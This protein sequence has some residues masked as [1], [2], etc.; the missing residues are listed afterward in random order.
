MS[1][2]SN[3]TATLLLVLMI[4]LAARGANQYFMPGDAFFHTVLTEELLGK[5]DEQADP[6]FIYHRP[7]FLPQM[8]CGYAGFQQLQYDK[9]PKSM[10]DNLRKVYDDLR[11]DYPKRI[12][13]TDE[14]RVEKTED[15]DIDVPTG[16]K[17]YT[18]INGF[19][20]LFYNASFDRTK[21]H[22]AAKYNEDWAENFA[23]FGHGREHA[24]FE[25]LVPTAKAVSLE[26]R[27]AKLVKPLNV[28][29]PELH[30]RSFKTPLRPKEKLV[31]IV[32]P[33]RDFQLAFDGKELGWMPV[34]LYAVT[35]D[36]ITELMGNNG[37]WVKRVPRG[38]GDDPF[39]DPK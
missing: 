28:G 27:D 10:K 25:S 2:R 11:L 6:V 19:S 16:K 21:F 36:G 8:F 29:L 9:M 23:A 37:H 4:P 5:I 38:F 3:F 15:G 13:V 35:E 17:I 7:D 34:S 24:V 31:A 12:E 32:L 18:E 14:V 30:A 1:I 26:W 22:L 20:V 33:K 39:G